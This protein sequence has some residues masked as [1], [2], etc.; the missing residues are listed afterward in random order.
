MLTIATGLKE[1]KHIDKKIEGR[2]RKIR[3]LAAYPSI[4]KPVYENQEEKVKSLVQSV[5]HLVKRKMQIKAAIN[6]MNLNTFIDIEGSRY[7]LND[8]LLMKQG[9]ARQ[10]REV[11]LALDS[12]RERQWVENALQKEDNANI[13]FT[14]CFDPEMRDRELEKLENIIASLDSKLEYTNHMTSININPYEGDQFDN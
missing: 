11:L 1:L 5:R 2:I 3:E 4:R 12:S 8:I 6:E 9:C 7:S 14:E 10:L 13:S